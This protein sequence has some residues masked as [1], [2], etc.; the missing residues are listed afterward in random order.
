MLCGMTTRFCFV[1]NDIGIYAKL[2][3]FFSD[4]SRTRK[5]DDLDPF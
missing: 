5:Y 1:K 2:D 3:E 4:L